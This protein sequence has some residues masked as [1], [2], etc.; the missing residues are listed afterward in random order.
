MNI[1][2]LTNVLWHKTKYFPYLEEKKPNDESTT[3]LPIATTEATTIITTNV[4]SPD[5]C[6]NNGT[7][8][9][10]GECECPKFWEGLTCNMP[11]TKFGKPQRKK[12]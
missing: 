3:K 11:Q 6:Q 12:I 10:N 1:N 2:L 9:V 4:C 7:C 8:S 5:S